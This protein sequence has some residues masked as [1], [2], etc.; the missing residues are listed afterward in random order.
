MVIMRL[1]VRRLAL[2][3]LG[4]AFTREEPVADFHSSINLGKRGNQCVS[5]DMG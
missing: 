1:V 5:E 4:L 3:I 2:R